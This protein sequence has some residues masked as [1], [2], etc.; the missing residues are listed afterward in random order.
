[1]SEMLKSVIGG[2]KLQ[3]CNALI[4]GCNRGIGKAIMET[5]MKEGA[6]II[7]CTRTLSDETINIYQRYQKEYG[8]TI[9]PIQMDL[10]DEESIKSGMKEVTALHLPLDILVN[11]AG[12]AIFKPMMMTRLD[13]FKKIMQVNLYAPVIISQ[14]AIKLMLK[15]KKGS[16]INL[17]SVSGLDPN[18]GNSAYGAS[19]AAIAS[20]TRTFAVEFEKS[21][22]RTNAIAPGFIETDMNQQIASNILEEM[23]KSIYLERFGS[24]EEVAKLALF[25]ASDESSGV[26]GQ[27][28]RIDG[29]I[30]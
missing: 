27:V 24:A 6:N 14:Y 20:L 15:Q 17:S 11:N 18:A 7:A 1:M 22:I 4:T 25:L 23:K 19:K 9:W 30:S 2:G 28:I 26:N 5:F 8:V 16:I 3:N 13:D 29:G 12:M 21:G 10:A